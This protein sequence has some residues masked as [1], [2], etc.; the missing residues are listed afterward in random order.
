MYSHDQQ[1]VDGHLHSIRSLDG[2]ESIHRVVCEDFHDWKLIVTLHESNFAVWECDSFTFESEI[3]KEIE[4][5][6]GV[7]MIETQT[8]TF[9]DLTTAEAK[10]GDEGEEEEKEE[11]KKGAK[12]G[13]KE[14]GVV[15]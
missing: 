14:V 6:E 11:E 3:L 15:W 5:C 1:V 10:K 9:V 2:L 4:A 8:Y 7:T 12:K 13:E